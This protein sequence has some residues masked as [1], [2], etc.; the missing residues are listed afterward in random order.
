MDDYGRYSLGEMR[1]AVRRKLDELRATVEEG[2]E[3]EIV[4]FGSLITNQTI[5]FHLRAALTVYFVDMVAS[6]ERFYSEEEYINVIEDVDEYPLPADLGYLRGLYWKSEDTTSTQV[7]M[8]ER[9]LMTELD[10]DNDIGGTLDNDAPMYRIL[11]NRI[12]LDRTP[13]KN[14]NLGILVSYVKLPLP[15]RSEDDYLDPIFPLILQEVMILDSVVEISAQVLKIDTSELRTSLQRLVD[16]LTLSVR[17]N[18]LPK[19]V[20]F[21]PSTSLVETRRQRSKGVLRWL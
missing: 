5:D 8:N 6:D 13:Q 4:D 1:E 7:P 11:M 20:R 12:K 2:D 16:R 21:R 15:L 9:K 18:K 17:M 14:N 19:T 3:T 10:L